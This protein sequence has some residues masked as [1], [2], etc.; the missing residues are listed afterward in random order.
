MAELPSGTVTFLLSDVEGSTALWEE[1]PE[2]M[3]AA[4]ARHDALF[5]PAVEEHGG[6]HIRPRGEGDSRFAVFASATDS[7]AAAVAIQRAFASEDWP[8][9]RPIKVRMGIHTGE[10]E[11][12]DGDYYGSAVNRCARLRSIGHGGQL[13]LSGV[14]SALV[15]DGMPSGAGLLD[16]GQHRLKDLTTSEHVFQVV[17][18]DLASDFPP[19]ASL[20]ARPHNLPTH[21]TA[22]LGRERELAEV[23]ALFAEGARLV[24]LTGPGGTGKT[25]LGLQVA[26]DL[27]EAFEQGVFL[28]ELAPIS[29]PALVP[30]TIAQALGVRDI[31]SRPIVDALKE[32]LRSRSV[33]LLLDNFEQVLPAASVVADLLAACPTLGALVTSREPLRLR[34]EH[35]YAV[36]PLALPEPRQA[37]TAA[38]ASTS[39]AVALF[40]QRAHAI[41][42]AFA[43]T[44]ENAPAVSEIC[45]RLDGLPLGIELAAARVRLLSPEAVAQR[46]EQRLPLLVGGA[47]DL[48]ARQR[49]LRDTI[50]WSHDLLDEHERRLFRRLA[51]F[52]GGW[53][54]EAAEA[55]CNVDGDLDVLAGLESVVSKSLA[56]HDTDARGEPRFR[57]L[58][59][60]REFAAERLDESG[61]TATLRR[62]H[63]DHCVMLA[64]QAE[65][66]LVRL[67][68]GDWLDRLQADHDNLRAALAW[69]AAIETD[70]DLMGRLAGPLSRFWEMRGHFGEGRRWLEQALERVSAPSPRIKLLQG[71]GSLAYHQDDLGRA[72]ALFAEMAELARAQRDHAAVV[73]GL[74]W[75]GLTAARMGD[76]PR[77]EL[78]GREGVALGRQIGDSEKLAHALVTF[79]QVELIRFDPVRGA[80]VL[81]EALRLARGTEAAAIW[82]PHIMQSLSRAVIGLGDIERAAALCA[83]A[84][85]LFRRRGD[86]LG[87]Q[88]GSR[89][90]MRIARL[91]GDTEQAA[92]VTRASLVLSR[93]LGARG[94]LAVGFESLAWIARV[95]GDHGRAVR[96][97]GAADALR[98]ALGR[99]ITRELRKGRD[100]DRAVA[101][102]ALG[103]DAFETAWA[104]G[105]AM[106]LEQAIAYALE[107]QPST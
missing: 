71:A 80:A 55:V 57:M 94:N 20:D 90:L 101:R 62:L 39:P 6:L 7:V 11:L 22:L 88:D 98:R 41:R 17:V 26:A 2:A 47:R 81:D 48:P 45:A 67:D 85:E 78:L 73:A 10:A 24:T 54:L 83:E 43:L 19:L 92:A 3:R 36:L 50:A 42:A 102:A 63:F 12:R 38:G 97:L 35:E 33:L 40:V 32:Y 49:A 66:R 27:L 82:V 75:R 79:A 23:R 30:S 34:G 9:P 64:E 46:L 4:L 16:L 31:G 29:D 60:I 25:R 61:E 84:D 14:T 100:E 96:L 58:E 21:P 103:Q 93:D 15:R 72:D 5:D 105:R 77:A 69:S 76:Y 59:T 99:P 106:I 87:L 104:E 70:P 86:I 37:T 74:A 68:A 107:E 89:L 28:V 18:D 91:R 65:P 44:D 8:T 1:A 95:D 53:T 51:V 13:L 56:R 52:V